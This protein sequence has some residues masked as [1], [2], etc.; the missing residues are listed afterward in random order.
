MRSINDSWGKISIFSKSL[1][2]GSVI[3]ILIVII[4]I[5]LLNY[6]TDSLFCFGLMVIPTL[7]SVLIFKGRLDGYALI[8]VTLIFWFLLGSLIGFLVYK[9][10]KNK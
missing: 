7:P 9:I 8:L 10:K 1:I 5:V 4:E 3:S 2:I 6:C